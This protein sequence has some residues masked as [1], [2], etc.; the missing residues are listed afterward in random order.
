[1][2]KKIRFSGKG[3]IKEAILIMCKSV[4]D[5]LVPLTALIIQVKT[6]EFSKSLNRNDFT[7]SNDRLGRFK[8]HRGIMFKTV[9]GESASGPKET[10][11]NWKN[12][13]LQPNR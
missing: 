1:M 6:K 8:Q 10:I 11:G 12:D 3:E 13:I 9:C 5:C 4:W 7:T 2:H